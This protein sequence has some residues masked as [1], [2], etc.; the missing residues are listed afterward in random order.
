MRQTSDCSKCFCHSGCPREDAQGPSDNDRSAK[1][2]D[3]QDESVPTDKRS[4]T[5]ILLA[6]PQLQLYLLKVL[7]R[8]QFSKY[9]M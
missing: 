7:F 2:I 6:L 3:Y 1:T 4:V 9:W 8:K 5:N